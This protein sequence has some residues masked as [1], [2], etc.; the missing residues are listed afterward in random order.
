[1]LKKIAERI[2]SLNNKLT[3][4]LQSNYLDDHQSD[5]QTDIHMLYSSCITLGLITVYTFMFKFYCQFAVQDPNTSKK[6]P[7][8]IKKKI[9]ILLGILML[10]K[11]TPCQN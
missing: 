8:H 2:I 10:K 1:M 3:I 7:T 9:L 5:G 4:K 11:Y 6:C